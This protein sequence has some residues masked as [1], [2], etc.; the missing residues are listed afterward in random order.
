MIT[1]RPASNSK[2][3]P[4]IGKPNHVDRTSKDPI[5]LVSSLIEASYG[6]QSS[7]E[8]QDVLID[9]VVQTEIEE[10]PRKR[11]KTATE[12][13]ARTGHA[14]VGAKGEL[15][16]EYVV[17]K[18]N[19][20]EIKCATRKLSTLE[21]PVRREHIRPDVHWERNDQGGSSPNYI[22]I[23]DKDGGNVFLTPLSQNH[24]GSQAS[25]PSDL[26]LKNTIQH[27]YLEDIH[28]ALLVD[29]DSAKWLKGQG[30]LWTEF[31]IV[32][33]SKD[34]VDC[35]QL[36]L[37]VK[38]NITSTPDQ[39]SPA[40]SKTPA[41]SRVL[42][43]YFPNP[44]VKDSDSWSPQDFYQSA[45]STNTDDEVSASIQTGELKSKLFPFRKYSLFLEL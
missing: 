36:I 16:F 29:R 44:N 9:F 6:P 22:Q 24:P 27:Q 8:L 1:R 7:N 17:V 32:L 45:N 12:K 19:V 25:V 34:G 43:A 40:K 28:I 10:P 31:D 41:V 13:R 30:K 42:A 39:I 21:T 4:L 35:I 37:T 26:D 5:L 38:W 11:Q 15:E 2:G 14:S 33:L 18:K 3:F 23:K 20:L